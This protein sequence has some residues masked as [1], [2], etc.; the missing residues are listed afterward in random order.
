VGPLW[1]PQPLFYGGP[2][3]GKMSSGR[4]VSSKLGGPRAAA[5][6]FTK[7]GES[8]FII[9]TNESN[10][11]S[12]NLPAGTTTN[13]IVIVALASDN[14]VN[15]GAAGSDSS[16]ITTTGYVFIRDA[17]GAVP[18]AQCGYKI[19]GATP[20]TTVVVDSGANRPV[21]GLIQVWRGVNTT[22]P[23]DNTATS[24]TGASGQPNPPSFT[25]VTAGALRIVVGFLD[26]DDVAASVT[27]PTGYTNLVASDTGQ[28]STTAG[29]TVMIASKVAASTG[30]E[31]P[32]AFGGGDDEWVA[33]H[34]ALRPA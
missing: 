16:G 31:D 3:Q 30:A 26:D 33:L 27:A 18:G 14:A 9:E 12:R 6:G 20:D 23:I 15:S 2:P 11:A 34:F 10:P 4:L 25:T 13:D 22:T 28:A 8:T 19:M 29:A 5:A 7:V 32:A 17:A 24:A 21:A 1:I